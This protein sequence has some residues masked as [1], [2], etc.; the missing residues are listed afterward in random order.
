MRNK[1]TIFF[2]LLFCVSLV[3]ISKPVL[4]SSNSRELSK[5]VDAYIQEIMKRFP[6]PGLAVG[7]VKGDEVLYL[8]GYGTANISG[9]LVTPQTPFMLV[10]LT[11]TFTALAIQQ[12]V[13]AGMIN[14]DAPVQTYIPEFQVADE[15]VSATITV[16]HLLDHTSGISTIEGTEPYLQSQNVQFDTA[17]KKLARYTP[18]YQPG[19]HYEYSNWNY[20]LLGE[21]ISRVSNQPYVE[22]MQNNILEPLDMSHASFADYHTL[23]GA[24]TGNLI[25][26][27][28]SVPY[29]EKLG[30]ATLS[31]GGLNASAEEMTHYLLTFFNHGQYQENNLLGRDGV[32]WFDTSWNWHAGSHGNLSES[33]S[34]A[35]NS[36][37]TNIQ[38]FPLQ[39]IG[40]VILMNTRLDQIVPGPTAHDIAFNIAQLVMKYPYEL[41]SNLVFYGGYTVLD[42]IFLLLMVI[43]FW[44]IFHLKDLSS[45][46]PKKGK[47]RRIV[48]WLGIFLQFSISFGIFIL[49]LI[50]GSRWNIVIFERPDF[51][52]P[53]LLIGVSLGLLGLIKIFI[54]IKPSKSMRNIAPYMPVNTLHLEDDKTGIGKTL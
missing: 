35:H 51:A 25:V 7:I 34:G 16:R 12:L 3:L 17:L 28:I 19:E 13:E 33:F 11:K 36:F 18:E 37:N 52:I 44:Q 2:L 8:Q 41:P 5:E 22:Y 23:P 31:A 29:N 47:A 26:F 4:A 38:L 20:A 40:V 6:I 53:I 32:G 42:T 39:K 50:L 21:L 45:H 10:S 46:T 30:P 9:D 43:I 14:L 54:H 48:I 49:P 15:L 1:L 24:A 27:G